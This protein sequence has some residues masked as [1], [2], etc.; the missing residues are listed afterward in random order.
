MGGSGSLSCLSRVISTAP[1]SK[2]FRFLQI[3]FARTQPPQ[4]AQDLCLL[5]T[6]F[7]PFAPQL[8]EA[9][10]GTFSRKIERRGFIGARSTCQ[11][12]R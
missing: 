4:A 12:R 9:T 2:I 6:P 1:R 10:I 8:A 11:S 5:K 3:L 7:R